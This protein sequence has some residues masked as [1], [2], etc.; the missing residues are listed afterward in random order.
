MTHTLG[1]VPVG[2]G[3]HGFPSPWQPNQT[4]N[5]AGAGSGGWVAASPTLLPSG[6]PRKREAWGAGAEGP[7]ALPL[8]LP[9]GG[10]EAGCR[11]LPQCLLLLL[12]SPQ[13]R[14]KPLT[15]PTNTPPLPQVSS[16]PPQPQIC[17]F[18][19]PPALSAQVLSPRCPIPLSCSPAPGPGTSCPPIPAPAATPG[20]A[21][22]QPPQPRVALLVPAV[23]TQA[24]APGGSGPAGG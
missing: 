17:W 11:K 2:G 24:L 12:G 13:D 4:N 7:E 8:P 20:T 23:T 16:Q 5:T 18:V 22:P 14:Q 9:W 10:G 1:K 21:T 6:L 15:A 19:P 3:G